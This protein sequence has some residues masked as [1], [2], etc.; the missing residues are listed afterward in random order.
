MDMNFQ[1]RYTTSSSVSAMHK[2]AAQV[3]V[4]LISSDKHCLPLDPHA[5][6][7]PRCYTPSPPGAEKPL[8]SDLTPTTG[9]GDPHTTDKYIRPDDTVPLAGDV[10]QEKLQSR[11]DSMISKY[12]KRDAAI[13]AAVSSLA[14]IV[15]TQTPPPRSSSKSPERLRPIDEAKTSTGITSPSSLQS[16][17]IKDPPTDV[18][19]YSQSR[20][21]NYELSSPKATIGLY[22]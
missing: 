7:S 2:A 11:L 9:A 13:N 4:H 3:A 10:P 17:P 6:S 21:L 18:G 12:D 5:S 16:T 19:F 15:K 1:R 20:P 22:F 8:N 14:T